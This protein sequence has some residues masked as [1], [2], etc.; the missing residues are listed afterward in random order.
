MKAF[1]ILLLSICALAPAFAQFESATVLGTVQD[2]SRAVVAGAH[3]TL[4]NAGTGV[5]STTKTDGNGNFEF[6]NRRLG[7][8]RVRVAMQGFH[9][10]E[11]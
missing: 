10:P 8:Y 4:V 9:G 2:P 7:Q 3:V 5:T 1:R 11:G 6:V